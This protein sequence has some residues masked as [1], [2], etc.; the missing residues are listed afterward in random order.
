MGDNNGAVGVETR[1][2]S[3]RDLARGRWGE[4]VLAIDPRLAQACD[5]KHGPCPVCGGK[6][7]FRA[8]GDFDDIGGA[9]CNQCGSFK[10]GISLVGWYCRKDY[11]AASTMVSALLD[12]CVEAPKP[13]R[14]K[15]KFDIESLWRESVDGGEML[16]DYLRSRGLRGFV[17]KTLRLL[18]SH[19]YYDN[20][21]K[22]E[23]PCMVAQV[24]VNGVMVAIHRTY[25]KPDGHGK[26]DVPSPKKLT[27]GGV[28]GGAI[29]LYSAKDRLAITE[30]IETAIAVQQSTGIPTWSC[31][32][33]G[34]IK[35]VAIPEHVSK[36]S[37][38]CDGDTVGR[39]SA[40]AACR[41]LIRNKRCR[42]ISAPDGKDWLDVLNEQGAK[43]IRKAEKCTRQGRDG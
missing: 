26:A 42:V 24:T 20:G 23:H 4:V 6:D 11:R 32:S 21:K 13:K 8:F 1:I 9:I 36:V 14:A 10:D 33:A 25:L 18:T 12:N 5:G 39:S 40:Y 41:R 16:K 22:T 17:P 15:R 28:T 19:W 34:G 43:A 2:G 37:I 30:G 29:Q 38:W 3:V 7:R 31:I 27:N 35:S